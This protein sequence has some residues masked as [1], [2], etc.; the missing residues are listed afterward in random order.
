M[1]P[2][3]KESARHDI[4]DAAK[5]KIRKYTKKE[6]EQKLLEKNISTKG[7]LSVLQAAC[8]NNGIPVEEE[9][10][11]VVEGWEGKPKGMLQVLW[12]RGFINTENGLK[13]TYQSYSIKGFNDQFGN[14]CLETSL[15]EMISC[16]HDFEEEETVLQTIA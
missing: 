7:N 4:T 15:K 14:R 9:I 1:T 6:L 11:R 8:Q 3:E 2:E 10:S 5:K 13:K 12:E 16:C